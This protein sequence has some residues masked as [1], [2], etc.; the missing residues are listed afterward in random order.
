[1]MTHQFLRRDRLDDFR[2]DPPIALQKAKNNTF[3]R[4]AASAPAFSVTTE[5][6]LVEFALTL[7]SPGF[8]LGQVK[9]RFAQPLVDAADDLHVDTD[10][11]GEPVEALEYLDRTLQPREVLRSS[12]FGA[13][14]LHVTA[15]NA[16]HLERTAE[17]ALMTPQKVGRTTEITLFPCNHRQLSY[18]CGYETP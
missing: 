15:R 17:N 18:A 1:M 6:G 11:L 2:V 16:H 5:V 8:E 7:H 13:A 14:A 4:R 10:S 9:E 3:P 12:A